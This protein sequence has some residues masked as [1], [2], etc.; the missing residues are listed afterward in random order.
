MEHEVTLT[1]SAY[2]GDAIGRLPD[3]RAVFVPFALAGERVR[4]RIVEEKRGYARGELLQII[5]P[6]PHRVTSRCKHFFALGAVTQSCGG[7]QYQ[8][9]SYE[10]QLTIKTEIVRDQLQRIGHIERPPVAPIVPSPQDWN[11]RNHIQFHLSADGHL[12]FIDTGGADVLTIHE[13]HLP[14]PAVNT[15]WPQLR[16]DL[17][18]KLERV[19]VRAGSE[20]ELMLALESTSPEAPALELKEDV[21]VVHL[22]NQRATVMAGSD[23]LTMRVLDQDFRV[24]AGSFFQ[25]NLPV[26]EKMLRHVLDKLSLTPDSVVLDA[27]C[28]VGLFSR[29][30]APLCKQVIGIESSSSACDDFVFNLDPFENVELYEGAAEEVLPFLDAQ[31][32]VIIVDPPR[33]GLEK[34]VLDALIKLQAKTLVYVSCDPSTLARDAAR[35]IQGGYALNDVTPFDMFPQTYHIESVSVFER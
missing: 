8:N 9:I 2:G 24:S 28:G 3:G 11:Y 27:Y 33:A 16:F 10:Q 32:G 31:P 15:F 29:F 34:S 21:S 5:G 12:G 23:H 17:L 22:L 6:S 26:T 14:E 7:C 20:N 13:C 4:I 1:I 35:L 18:G 19:A 25:V 30:V